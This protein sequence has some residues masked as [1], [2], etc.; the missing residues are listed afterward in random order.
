MYMTIILLYEMKDRYLNIVSEQKL[1]R[2]FE[3][4]IRYYQS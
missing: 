1:E 3:Y 2:G 4:L